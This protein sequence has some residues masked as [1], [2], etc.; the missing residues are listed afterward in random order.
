MC[1]LKAVNLLS[2]PA[3]DAAMYAHHVAALKKR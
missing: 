1:K 3:N 2:M